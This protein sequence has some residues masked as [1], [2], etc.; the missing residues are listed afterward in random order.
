MNATTTQSKPEAKSIFRKGTTYEKIYNAILKTEG[1]ATRKAD[2]I[3]SLKRNHCKIPDMNILFGLNVLLSVTEDG[4]SHPR[5]NKK[6]IAGYWVEK[7][8]DG[9]FVF[10]RR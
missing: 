2:I 3:R 4:K 9:I 1:N 8:N 7:R 10:H 6:A 5:L